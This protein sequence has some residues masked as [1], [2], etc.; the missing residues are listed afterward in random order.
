[1][2]KIFFEY[3]D[4]SKCII[5]GKH[6]D[7]PL[8][9]AIKYQKQYHDAKI[10]IYQQYP[11]KNYESMSLCEKIEQ[12]ESEGKDNV[13]GLAMDNNFNNFRDLYKI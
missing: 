13:F 1:M 11:K 4:N 5:T 9:L 6:K 8:R 2:W 3:P 12:L 7:I 10:A